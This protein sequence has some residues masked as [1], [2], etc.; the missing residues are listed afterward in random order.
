MNWFRRSPRKIVVVHRIER[1]DDL[2]EAFRESM[3][4]RE[5][6]AKIATGWIHPKPLKVEPKAPDRRMVEFMEWLDAQAVQGPQRG[7]YIGMFEHLLG[8][9]PSTPAQ[10]ARAVTVLGKAGAPLPQV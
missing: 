2:L 9:R 1:L 6:V 4:T 7:D 8:T 5:R 10:R 3:E